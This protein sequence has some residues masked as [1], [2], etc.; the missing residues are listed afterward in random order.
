[1]GGGETIPKYLMAFFSQYIFQHKVEMLIV[2]VMF[3][4]S[5]IFSALFPEK[6]TFSLRD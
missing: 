5:L 3:S 4:L 1:M 6:L 2:D